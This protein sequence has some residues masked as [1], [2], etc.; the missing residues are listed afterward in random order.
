MFRHKHTFSNNDIEANHNNVTFK[1]NIAQSAGPALTVL[2]TTVSFTLFTLFIVAL[3]TQWQNIILLTYYAVYLIA[4]LSALTLSIYMLT[5]CWIWLSHA[6]AE[7]IFSRDQKRRNAVYSIGRNHVAYDK[8]ADIAVAQLTQRMTNNYKGETPSVVDAEVEDALSAPSFSTLLTNGMIIALARE[9]KNF[10]ASDKK[11]CMGYTNDGPRMVKFGDVR[12]MAISGMNG[13]GK[14]A[15]MSFISAQA[16]LFGFALVIVDHHLDAEQSISNKLSGLRN[17]MVC[18]PSKER[19]G[20]LAFQLVANELEI[21]RNKPSQTFRPWLVVIDELPG[22]VRWM[23]RNCEKE[24]RM[25]LDILT[26]I[27]DEGRKY[28]L[29]LIA[30]GQRWKQASSGSANLRESFAAQLQ[31]K[32]APPEVALLMGC[33][34]SEAEKAMRLPVGHMLVNDSVD[35]MLH[36]VVP[37][38]D[39][40]DINK[41]AEIASQLYSKISGRNTEILRNIPET[42]NFDVRND[43][44][45]AWEAKVD[46]FRDLTIKNYSQTEII[47]EI[48]GAK[49]GDNKKYRDAR[50]EYDLIKQQIVEEEQDS[51]FETTATT[52]EIEK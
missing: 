4:G 18:K 35:F 11:F 13:S 10:I 9:N 28:G 50:E 19:E 30:G 43:S 37:L 41:V 44:E 24:I 21:R 17:F 29:F 39:A 16:V 20:L 23:R 7:W 40:Y 51:W 6:Y 49:P 36:T 25:V 2:A 3:I 12:S 26:A 27:N 5:C 1:T 52:E 22:M 34:A 33:A 47:A 48:W 14:T 45:M 42:P 32:N 8:S 38:T 31:H 46:T 15:T